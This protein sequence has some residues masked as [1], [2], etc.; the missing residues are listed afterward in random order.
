MIKVVFGARG[1]VLVFGG[2]DG[3]LRELLASKLHTQFSFHTGKRDMTINAFN[4]F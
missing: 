4:D 1:D 3:R 2:G